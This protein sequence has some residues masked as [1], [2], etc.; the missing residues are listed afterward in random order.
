LWLVNDSEIYSDSFYADFLAGFVDE[1]V[2]ALHCTCLSQYS[3]PI[4]FKPGGTAHL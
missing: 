4:L 1:L 2:F 3:K